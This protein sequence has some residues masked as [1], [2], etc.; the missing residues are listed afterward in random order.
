[1]FYRSH[2]DRLAEMHEQVRELRRDV[3]FA[4]REIEDSVWRMSQA[5]VYNKIQRAL[6]R[7]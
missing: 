4:T 6:Q 3:Q 2:T 7:E 5:D 1:M